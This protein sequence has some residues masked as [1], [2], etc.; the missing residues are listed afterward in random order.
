METQETSNNVANRDNR[1]IATS[2]FLRRSRANLP[3]DL[4]EGW[5]TRRFEVY[6]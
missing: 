6:G 1:F 4:A 3:S 2:M 5:P